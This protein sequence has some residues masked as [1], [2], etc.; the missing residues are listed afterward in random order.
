V[1]DRRFW[2]FLAAA[3]VC[4]LL[5]PPTPAEVRW[6]PKLLVV[7]YA[8]LTALV[9]LETLTRRRGVRE[10]PSGPSPPAPNRRR[11]RRDA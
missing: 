5:I 1:S 11:R 9:A 2:F 3:V 7:V 6:V 8:V 10:R 4:G